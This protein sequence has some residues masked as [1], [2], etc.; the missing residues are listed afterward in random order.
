MD[1]VWAMVAE[2]WWIGPTVIGAGTLGW[3]GLRGQRTAKA[4]RLAYDASRE[5][6]RT[7]R[8]DATTARL[9]VRAA[10]AELT[11]AQAARTA[12]YGTSEEVA[13]ARRALDTAQR[14]TKAASA[15]LRARRAN[16]SA[17]RAALGA[18]SDD[19]AH[20]P[21]ARVM[22]ADDALTARWME[23]ETDAAKVLAFPAMSDARV[24]AT[25][26][27]HADHHRA[28]ALRPAAAT[29]RITPAQFGAYRD[30]VARMYRSFE[31]AESEAWRRARAAGSAPAGPGPDSARPAMTAPAEWMT[32]AQEIAQNL[33]QSMLAR[34]AEALSRMSTPRSRDADDDPHDPRNGRA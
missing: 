2:F 32:S 14:K 24:P 10:R 7:A 28:R 22:A 26:A 1:P 25:A 12:G 27:F 20:L 17:D 13:A 31:A 19:P 3:F 34:G 8:Q 18:R 33:T 16:L 15:T 9:G 5:A 6:L 29:S 21:L 30:A 23:Y 11:R 4:R